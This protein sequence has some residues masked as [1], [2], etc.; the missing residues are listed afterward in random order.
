[1]ISATIVLF[2]TNPKEINHV[3]LLQDL[4]QVPQEAK[5][6]LVVYIIL[7]CGGEPERNMLVRSFESKTAL[8]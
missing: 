4:S 6:G 5:R 3:Q 7:V 1:M 8:C 2:Q